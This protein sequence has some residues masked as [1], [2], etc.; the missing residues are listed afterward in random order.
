[1]SAHG[2]D[3]IAAFPD[4]KR[5]RRAVTDLSNRG[6]PER[7]IRLVS[8]GRRKDPARVS[9]MRAEMQEEVRD[10]V[11]G[12]GVVFTPSQSRG[13]VRG[14]LIGALAGVIVG[15]VVGAGWAAFF[16]SG[17]PL[18][19]RFAIAAVVFGVAGATIGFVGGGAMEPRLEAADRSGQMTDDRRPAG[20][21]QTLVSV[22]VT[23]EGE[24]ATVIDLLE[25][26]GASRVDSVAP[27]GSPLAPQSEHPRPADPPGWWENG[28]R[29][30]G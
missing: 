7:N 15:L 4:P 30:H 9:E 21:D 1:M 10:S 14:V 11:V 17:L 28:G 22:R 3:V 19:G 6:L 2:Y 26:S 5:A 18:A 29:S 8:G 23:D 27:D 24:G 16:D 25:R 12:P 13:V 20:Q